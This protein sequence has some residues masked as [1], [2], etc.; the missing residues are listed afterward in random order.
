MKG[1]EFAAFTNLQRA[2]DTQEAA[3]GE[4][5]DIEE[6]KPALEKEYYNAKFEKDRATNNEEFNKAAEHFYEVEERWNNLLAKEQTARDAF[7]SMSEEL[8]GLEEEYNNKKVARE[9]QRDVILEEGNVDVG[10]YD[11]SDGP[12]E[13]AYEGSGKCGC[14]EAGHK[15]CNFDDGDHGTCE[16]CYKFIDGGEGSASCDTDGLPDDGAADCKF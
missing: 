15:F 7:D 13:L 4:L 8:P 6:E 16:K 10:G 11:P 12:P 3:E 14:E 9:T 5:N 2:R 1:Q